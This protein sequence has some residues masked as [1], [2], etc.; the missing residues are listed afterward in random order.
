MLL[1]ARTHKHIS[2]HTR[3]RI[4]V[5][6][7]SQLVQYF[8]NYGCDFLQVSVRATWNAIEGKVMNATEDTYCFLINRIDS[9]V[10]VGKQKHF[11]N[12]L[13]AEVQTLFRMFK[14]VRL[15]LDVS[16]EFFASDVANV[17]EIGEEM[18]QLWNAH[19]VEGMPEHIYMPIFQ[20]EIEKGVALN[21][22]LRIK[23]E[24]FCNIC[25]SKVELEEAVRFLRSATVCPSIGV[26]LADIWKGGRSS[27]Y[28]AK[29]PMLLQEMREK[30][31]LYNR[32][33]AEMKLL[34]SR[35]VQIEEKEPVQPES[36]DEFL[37][38]CQVM[39][40]SL[41]EEEYQEL[42]PPSESEDDDPLEDSGLIDEQKEEQQV[43]SSS[44]FVE[45]A[46][47]ATPG[48]D[49]P[50]GQSTAKRCRIDKEQDAPV[51]NI[52]VVEVSGLCV[53]SASKDVS[54]DID[55]VVDPAVS[56]DL[57]QDRPTSGAL[58][59]EGTNWVQPSSISAFLCGSLSQCDGQSSGSTQGP[60]ENSP[61]EESAPSSDAIDQSKKRLIEE[62]SLAATNVV[63]DGSAKRLCAENV[64]SEA[65]IT[66]TTSD[67]AS[68]EREVTARQKEWQQEGHQVD[69][70]SSVAVNPGRDMPEG[71]SA[72]KRG[73]TE[74]EPDAPVEGGNNAVEVPAS[75]DPINTLPVACNFFYS[76][77][78]YGEIFWL[79]SQT[80]G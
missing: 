36:E 2:P 11:A 45:N 39:E 14:L 78:H 37:D 31:K 8:P 57:A 58:P 69:P 59:V 22:Q 24:I 49:V 12:G 33:E 19:D 21:Q 10:S 71:E 27:E 41:E 79:H 67:E 75:K 43:D 60:S 56:V 25:D 46:E 76:R 38:D 32:I 72:A 9:S 13:E 1:Q 61:L 7:R 5:F 16:F 48:R 35:A 6:F 18:E 47:M 42:I 44:S 74:K 20:R 29:I 63:S 15:P 80:C 62:S 54:N 23:A 55:R 52:N 3:K 26:V 17:P 70:S 51:G 65:T 34:E 50:E 4:Q 73:R 77:Q 68:E 66:A 53:A 40:E 28:K 30:C 64:P